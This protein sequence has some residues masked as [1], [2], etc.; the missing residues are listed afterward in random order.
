MQALSERLAVHPDE[1]RRRVDPAS[2]PFQTTAEVAP[3]EATIGQ[4]RAAEAIAFALEVDA[5]GFHLFAAGSPGTGREST[6]LAAVRHFAAAQPIPHDWVYVHNFAEADR[7]R[8]FPVPAGRGR[9]LA[10]DM[11]SFVEAARQEI[12][13]AFES[14]DYARR[15]DR[16]LAEVTTRRDT[17]IAELRTFAQAH[18]YALEMTPTGIGT[19][20]LHDGQPMTPQAFE[21]LTPPEKAD[22][23][24]RG[25]QVQT[26]IGA[27]V[28]QMR[29]IEK[30]AQERV[31]AL[32]REVA[33][34]A[35]GPLFAELQEAYADLSE[36]LAFIAQVEQD[37]PEHLHDFWPTISAESPEAAMRLAQ[38]QEHLARYEVNV[39]IDNGGLT[40]APVVVERNPTYYNLIG[41]LDY[42]AIMGAMV[43]DFRQ[44]K[45]GALHRANGGFLVLHALDVL[46]N[47]FAWEALKRSLN[48]GEIEIENLGEQVTALPTSR[49]RPEPIPLDLKLILIG[50]AALYQV[51]H[52]TDEDFPELFGVKA[53]FAPDMDWTEENLASYAAFLSRVV[54]DRELHHF[55]RA[56]VA[57]IAEH[58][59]RLRDH[60]RKLTA[61]VLDIAK[62]AVEASHWAGAAGHEV[63]LAEDVDTAIANQERRR[64]LAEERTREVIVD[65]T[66]MIDTDG[67]RVA[68]VNGLSVLD[69]GDYEFGRPSRVTARVSV[70]RGTIQSI[71]REIELSG[72]IHSKGFLILTGYLQEQYAQHWPLSLG[73]TITFEQSYGEIDGDSA[74]S[75]EL[76]ALLSALSGL[77]LKQGIAVTGA[78]NQHGEV[79]AVGGVTHKI[80]GFYEICLARGLTGDQGVIVPAANVK[81]L[82]LKDDLVAAVRAGIF[83]VWAVHHVDEGIELLTG[84]PAGDREAE[85]TYPEGS[86]HRLVQDRLRGYANQ[87]RAFAG[88]LDGSGPHPLTPSPEPRERGNRGTITEGQ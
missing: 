81:N 33:L 56:A 27:S 38:R 51:L 68:Q 15:R 46:R 52:Q 78:V 2:L 19:I 79:Q 31:E 66:V 7:P 85:G 60:Q 55:D 59:A 43:T 88:R 54:R 84:T 25:K 14:E 39:L 12:P 21:Q 34:F 26:E 16:A 17:L 11:T 32:D 35:A 45:P 82:M 63:V 3:V 48:S 22:I 24:A 77:P 10:R 13:R 4:P 37:L 40:G 72:P 36:A 50:P 62:L 70:G 73:A 29:Q 53:D 87:A 42:R 47:P 49:P 5:R 86:V 57:R 23:E 74:S 83:H 28:R 18:G 6:V 1:L 44:I 65:G 76:Y 20:A 80:E 30:E 75:T 61:R 64:N 69:V 41:R 9:R 8:A 58:G 67:E 71:E